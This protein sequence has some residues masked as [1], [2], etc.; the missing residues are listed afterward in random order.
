[1]TTLA[2][3]PLLS[4]TLTLPRVGA[5]T[6]EAL[7]DSDAALSGLVDLVIE[8]RTW[9]GTVVRGG[10]ELS[11]WSGRVVGAGALASVLGPLPLADTDLRTV[12]V[13]TLREVGA[14]L[15]ADAGDLSAAVARWARI[16]APAAHTVA[17]VAKAAGYSWRV[18]P[19]G[20]VWLGAETWAPLALGADLDLL[21]VDPRIGRHEL[22]G[23]DA[24]AIEPGRVV[25]LDG[26]PVRVGAVEHRLDGAAV[27]TMVFEE[28]EGD[29]GN[30]LLAA[31]EGIIN[32]TM[33]RVD[34]LALYPCAVVHQRADG[35]L[36]LRPDDPRLPAPQSVPYRTLRGL[37]V[38]VPDGAR[39]LLGYEG[40]DPQT[41]YAALWEIGD[42]TVVRVNG[43]DTKV[44]RVGDTVESHTHTVTVDGTPYTT[45]P[46]APAITGGSSALRVP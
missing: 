14:E 2:G 4:F 44:A 37:S 1:M 39:V 16:A 21:S 32:R 23:N 29:P 20:T 27:R 17:D 24:L 9:R 30:R 42:A 38:E 18:R 10:V 8:G 15:A 22:G 40:G 45:T 31:L 33:R 34:Y 5:W 12:V 6:L 36:D 41:P 19:D 28:R 13:E 26:S 7:V 46:A 3:H 43:G 35:T 11:R 25:T